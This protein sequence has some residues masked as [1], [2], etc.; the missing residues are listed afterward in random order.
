MLQMR[1]RGFALRDSFADALR[2]I[3]LAEEVNDFAVKDVT[4]KHGFTSQEKRIAATLGVHIPEDKPDDSQVEPIDKEIKLKADKLDSLIDEN[5]LQDRRIKWL[6]RKKLS[7]VEEFSAK[8]LDL[9]IDK[10]VEKVKVAKDSALH[11]EIKG[12]WDEQNK[13]GLTNEQN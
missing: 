8:D 10:V 9:C 2:G 1:A 6:D 7:C 11:D 12:K 3:S 4:P 13:G 5:G